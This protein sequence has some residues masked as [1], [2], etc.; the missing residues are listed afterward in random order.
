MHGHSFE[1]RVSLVFLG[2]NFVAIAGRSGAGMMDRVITMSRQNFNAQYV[3]QLPV[4][5]HGRLLG[6]AFNG[7]QISGTAFFHTGLPFSVLS[8]PYTANGNGIVQGS[9]PQYAKFV[10]GCSCL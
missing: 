2:W 6:A 10:P 4:K 8:A 3:Y 7:W 9:G 5:V 1:W